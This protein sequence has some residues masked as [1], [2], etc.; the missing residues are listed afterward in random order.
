MITIEPHYLPNLEYFTVLS[1]VDAVYLD[2]ESPYKKQTF[3]NRA[4]ILGPNGILNLIV[5]VHY[6]Q[7]MSLEEVKIDYQQSWVKDH[8][9]AILSSYGKSPFFEFFAEEFHSVLRLKPHHLVELNH[10][11][12]S[13]CFQMLQWQID[14]H[15]KMPEN[16]VYDLRN[17]ILPKQSFENRGFYKP[18]SYQ[19]NFGNTFVPNLSILDLL[20]CQGSESGRILRN[21]KKMPIELFAN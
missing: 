13:V 10:A 17:A 9:G 1:Q 12:L 18:I 4:S 7:G 15:E 5:P 3:R 14:I 16:H 21:S 20:F 11:M 8:W 19:Q 2:Q 6:S